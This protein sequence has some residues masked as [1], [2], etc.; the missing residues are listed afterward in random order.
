MTP[1]REVGGNEDSDMDLEPRKMT[2]VSDFRR[3]LQAVVS[4]G[5][6]SFAVS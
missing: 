3:H 6:N 4:S 2:Y 5:L 1:E